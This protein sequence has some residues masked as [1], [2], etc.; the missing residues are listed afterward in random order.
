[1][2]LGI[3]LRRL[4]IDRMLPKNQPS[5]RG[6]KSRNCEGEEEKGDWERGRV[7]WRGPTAKESANCTKVRFANN[8]L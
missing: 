6:R 2:D 8:A 3:G 7:R 1:M 4:G 5:P